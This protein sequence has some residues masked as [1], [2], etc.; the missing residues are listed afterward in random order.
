MDQGVHRREADPGY[1]IVKSRD[2]ERV[3]EL[4]QGARS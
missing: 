1:G 3:A 2:T 4:N